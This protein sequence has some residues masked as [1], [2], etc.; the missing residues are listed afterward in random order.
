M[1]TRKADSI[2]STTKERLTGLAEDCIRLQIQATGGLIGGP[3]GKGVRQLVRELRHM[4]D[5]IDRPS[6]EPKSRPGTGAV[7]RVIDEDGEEDY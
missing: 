7:A 6:V 4:Y 1:A 5:E 2:S 3:N